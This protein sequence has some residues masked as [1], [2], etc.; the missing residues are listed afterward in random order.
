[1]KIGMFDSGIGGLTVLNEALKLMPD[2]AY[3]YY[4]DTDN[5]PYGNKTADRIRAYSEKAVGFLADIGCDAVV[6]ACNTA[7]AVAA[8]YLRE[9]F[10]IPIIGIEPAVK[11]AV[12]HNAGKRILVLATEVTAHEK[13][14]EDLI[15]RVDNEKLVDVKAMP[16]L[17]AF[18]EKGEFESEAVREYLSSEMSGIDPAE[19]GTIVFGCTHFNHFKAAVRSVFGQDIELIDGSAGTVRNLKKTLEGMGIPSEGK[20]RIKYYESGREV[21]DK[22]KLAFFSDI[23]R[24]LNEC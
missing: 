13:K 22:E 1:M 18:A 8:A 9:R 10:D 24:H 2:E 4:A 7:T 5:V 23:I 3:F 17:V 19:Y 16:G 12:E 6:I 20:N 14:L 15:S 11:P 21:A